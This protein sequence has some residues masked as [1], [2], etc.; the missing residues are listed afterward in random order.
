MLIHF[1][2]KV[3]MFSQSLK[4]FTIPGIAFKIWSI[5]LFLKKPVDRHVGL[6]TDVVFDRPAYKIIIS[7]HFFGK[8]PEKLFFVYIYV[9][10]NDCMFVAPLN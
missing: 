10:K 3:F 8:E 1:R 6:A 5:R 4:F 7:I 9:K 2:V